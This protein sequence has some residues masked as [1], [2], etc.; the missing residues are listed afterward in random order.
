[1]GDG[2]PLLVGVGG[3]V[4]VLSQSFDVQ[5]TAHDALPGSFEQ[6]AHGGALYQNGIDVVALAEEPE[7]VGG[8]LVT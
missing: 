8:P 2:R 4:K 3:F 1:M 6:G 7:V 5:A